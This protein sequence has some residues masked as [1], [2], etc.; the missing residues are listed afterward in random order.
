MK[1]FLKNS[2]FRLLIIIAGNISMLIFLFT[3][4]IPYSLSNPLTIVITVIM[5]FGFSVIFTLTMLCELCYDEGSKHLVVNADLDK[6]NHWMSLMSKLD[7]FRWYRAQYYVF[8]TIYYR[9]K[10][11][12]E[13]LEEILKKQAFSSNESMDLV[14]VYNQFLL[15]MHKEN[16]EAVNRYYESISNTY[17][18]NKGEGSKSVALIYSLAIIE[19]EKNMYFKQYKT[20]MRNLKNVQFGKLNKREQ[21]HYYYLKYQATF[22]GGNKKGAEQYFNLAKSNYPHGSFMEEIEVK[23]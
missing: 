5:F 23:S 11:D 18:N 14:Y 1:K 17:K 6:A 9:D 22:F 16:D 20:V 2:I 19:A 21:A 10:D 7:Q 3:Y 8:L 15:Q 13:K 4:I 12:Y